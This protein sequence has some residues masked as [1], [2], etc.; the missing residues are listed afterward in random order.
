MNSVGAGSAL[1]AVAMLTAV[2]VA[3][4]PP[5]APRKAKTCPGAEE[6]RSERSRVIAD[7]MSPSVTGSARH[8]LTPA[9]IASRMSEGSSVGRIIRT[10]ADGY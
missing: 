1:S 8:S 9:R 5:F 6:A 4:T 7:W 3:P 10:D 2:V